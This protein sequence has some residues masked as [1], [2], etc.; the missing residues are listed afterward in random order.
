MTMSSHVQTHVH[1]PAQ[2]DNKKLDIY[3]SKIIIDTFPASRGVKGGKVS[4]EDFVFMYYQN[5]AA[6]ALVIDDLD[7]AI[8]DFE[9]HGFLTC[10]FRNKLLSYL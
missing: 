5:L 7:R 8:V 6:K 10:R 4:D 1:A 2:L 9:N 3:F